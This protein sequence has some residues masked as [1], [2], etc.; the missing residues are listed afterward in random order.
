M[1]SNARYTDFPNCIVA[2]LCCLIGHGSKSV[3]LITQYCEYIIRRRLIIESI[4]R[5]TCDK[6]QIFSA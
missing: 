1:M 6:A 4:A 5:L 2:R 3:V